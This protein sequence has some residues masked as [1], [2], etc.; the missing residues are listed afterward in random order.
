MSAGDCWHES[1]FEWLA[2]P[3]TPISFAPDTMFSGLE[4]TLFLLGAA[5][6]GVVAFRMMHLPPMLGYLVVGIVIGPH[7]LGFA[8][9]NETTTPWPSSGWCS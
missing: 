1:G 5:V 4:L 3:I 9:D 7:G 2:A 8:E 6:L